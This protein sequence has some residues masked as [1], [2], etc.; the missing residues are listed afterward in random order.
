MAKNKNLDKKS[1]LWPKI[2]IKWPKI[3]ILAN[4]RTF[5]QKSKFWLKLKLFREKFKLW[6]KLKLFREKLKFWSKIKILVKNKNFRQKSTFW[7]HK[8]GVLVN[9][10]PAIFSCTVGDV[11]GEGHGTSKKSAKHQAAEN[12]L[13]QLKS[14]IVPGEEKKVAKEELPD[15]QLLIHGGEINPVGTLQVFIE[16]FRNFLTS[17]KYIF[18]KFFTFFSL[19]R[20]W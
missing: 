4:N 16:N 3:Q 8:I 2:K 12:V 17:K 20:R 6:L 14:G 9:N 15:D 18:V 13:N 5:G 10:I 7:Q 1:K 19:S 11:T